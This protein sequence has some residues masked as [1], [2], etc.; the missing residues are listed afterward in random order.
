M[1]SVVKKDTPELKLSP[2]TIAE[3]ERCV[4]HGAALEH[5][6]ANL[7]ALCEQRDMVGRELIA[8]RSAARE[9]RGHVNMARI[10][11]LSK[12]VQSFDAKIV[13]ERE[14]AVKLRRERADRVA[15]ALAAVR[16]DAARRLVAA[17]EALAAAFNDLNGCAVAIRNAGD[18]D[19]DL[20]FPPVVGMVLQH[21]QQVIRLSK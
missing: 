11:A 8:A 16:L 12:E 15:D 3:V 10:D 2:K 19:Q 9:A 5:A 4:P 1:F 13:P 6:E 20:F 18:P 21:A 14:K 17:V 7:S